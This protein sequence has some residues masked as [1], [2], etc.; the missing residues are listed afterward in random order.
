MSI[1]IK[2]RLGEYSVKLIKKINQKHLNDKNNFYIIDST[3]YKIFIK[4]K[5]NK[6]F[7]LVNSSEKKK[8]LF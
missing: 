6:N 7:I 5:L 4:K 3:V 2:S 1:T 8:R